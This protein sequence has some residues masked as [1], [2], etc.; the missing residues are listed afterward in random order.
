[1][2]LPLSIDSSNAD[3]RMGGWRKMSH[4]NTSTVC[5]KHLQEMSRTFLL[6]NLCLSLFFLELGGGV[7]VMGKKLPRHKELG[8][9]VFRFPS[10]ERSR[11]CFAG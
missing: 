9:P 7:Q 4:I 10:S 11:K 1:M 8:R 6:V 2:K 3:L 5:G